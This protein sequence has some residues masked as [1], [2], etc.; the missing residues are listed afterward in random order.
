MDTLDLIKSRRSIRKYTPQQVSREDLDC[1]VEAGLYAANAGGGQRSMIVAIRDRELAKRIGSLNMAGFSRRGLAGNYVS[2]DQPSVIDDPS[3]RNGFY[4]APT[5][6]CVFCQEDFLFSVADA[7]AMVQ[8]MSLEAHSLGLA[9]CIVSRAE[10][11][12]ASAEGEALLREWGVSGN[13]ICR[14]FLT[15]G[16]CDG[17]YPKAM[18]RRDGRLKI[19][20]NE[21]IG[22][23][24]ADV[25]TE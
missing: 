10:T 24:E 4:G 25:A 5:V 23:Y 11:T 8:T 12:F 16:Y 7:F 17:E 15:L 13:Y 18:S 20:D 1:A 9:S 3:I 6:I 19:V 22:P 2:R 21:K 14:A